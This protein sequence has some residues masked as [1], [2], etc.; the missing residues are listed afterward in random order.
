M[1]TTIPHDQ[2]HTI[3]EEMIK[4]LNFQ[5]YYTTAEFHRYNSQR[6][7]ALERSERENGDKIR[8]TEAK[9]KEI[10]KFLEA[11]PKPENM[12]AGEKS[13]RNKKREVAKERAALTGDLEAAKLALS[14]YYVSTKGFEEEMRKNI[15]NLEGYKKQKAFLLTFDFNKAV[16]EDET[17]EKNYLDKKE[18]KGAQL[19]S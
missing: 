6:K 9:I 2:Q 18:A 15:I 19:A 16:E 12:E 11:L 13:D 3:K 14:T 1:K 5:I 4:N 8:T 10:V 7:E 17:N